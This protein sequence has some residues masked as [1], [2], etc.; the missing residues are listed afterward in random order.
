MRELLVKG[1][2]VDAEADRGWTPLIR[3]A[4]RRGDPIDI[5][6][7]LLEYGAEVN[8]KTKDDRSALH[9]ASAAGNIEIVKRLLSYERLNAKSKTS[10]DRWGNTPNRPVVRTDARAWAS[11]ATPFIE[12]AVPAH[13]E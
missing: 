9:V 13:D 8:A 11:E 12:M 6:N 5:V 4:N 7:A 2:L 1:A 3:A 10:K